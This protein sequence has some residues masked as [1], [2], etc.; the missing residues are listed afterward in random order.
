VSVHDRGVYVLGLH[1]G[2]MSVVTRV[3]NL[4]GVPLAEQDD[5]FAPDVINPEGYWKSRPLVDVNDR[6]LKR[7]GGSWDARLPISSR[8]G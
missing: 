8:L 4:L 2:G 1:R 3:V 6:L 7:L 5:L